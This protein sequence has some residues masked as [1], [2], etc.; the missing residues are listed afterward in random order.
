MHGRIQGLRDGV[1]CSREAL[2]T[3]SRD[4]DISRPLPSHF[5]RLLNELGPDSPSI[6]EGVHVDD[7]VP[8]SRGG[9]DDDLTK[10]S[11][12]V[13]L[14]A[15]I[16]AL[17]RGLAESRDTVL[18]VGPLALDLIERT[19]K[20]GKRTID[21]LPREFR[22]LQYMMRRKGETLTRAM[23]LQEV[24]NYKFVPESNVVDVHMG[25]LRRKVDA[26]HETPMIHNVR[27]VGFILRAPV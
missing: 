11:A 20:R 6:I 25:R 27:G 15:G 22:L 21:L 9:G 17:L 5:V 19:A 23:L 8:A 18:Q 7:R 3:V 26:P 13:E 24:W 1:D 2:A 16:E 12:T 14:I 4:A 10:P